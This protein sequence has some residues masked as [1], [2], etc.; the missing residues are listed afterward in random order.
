MLNQKM[1][2]NWYDNC[3]D[4][5]RNE[6]SKIKKYVPGKSM[7][8]VKKEYDL[9]RVIKLAS[10]E[11]PIGVSE[12]VKE[13]IN[14][15]AANINRYPDMDS[16]G[17]KD[18]LLEKLDINSDMI[19]FGNGSDGLLKVIAEVFLKK[20]DQVIISYP[21]F[22]EY[23][24][25]SQL[26]G[27]QLIRVWM[28][29]YIQNI[30]G[31]INSI[32]EDTK[33]IFLTNPHNP[34]GTIIKRKDLQVLLD[35]LPEDLIV[36]LDEAYYEYVSDEEY[37][38]GLDYIRED[39]PVIV[40]RTFSKAYGLAGLRLGYALARPELIDYIMRARDP[41]NVNKVAENAGIAALND[42]EYMKKTLENNKKGKEYL[43]NELSKIGLKYVPTEANFIL[44]NI[45]EHDSMELFKKLQSSG[46][47]I[48]PGKLLGYQHH[49]RVSIGTTE[50]N[51]I[52]IK[53][54]KKY[55]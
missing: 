26:M 36:V 37:P 41:F 49:I 53:T 8:E 23:K 34:S 38:D 52:F 22:V 10:N 39:Y 31:I 40:L 44:V 48:R 28:N 55:I 50:E 19:A 47:I 11:N 4:M 32:T 18:E 21:S 27:S 5:V 13:R 43:Y 51:E 30:E 46:I 24:F 54:L 42:K 20:E 29:D 35:N 14:K 45:K 25:V 6:V 33:L 16:R 17:L 7:D 2:G 1:G 3:D 15:V 12:K 9:D